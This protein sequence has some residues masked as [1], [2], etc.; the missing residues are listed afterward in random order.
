MGFKV[1]EDFSLKPVNQYLSFQLL[2]QS[3]AC[4]PIAML[5]IMKVIDS[6]VLKL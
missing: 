4:P 3:H 2:S 1:S 5:P 6:K